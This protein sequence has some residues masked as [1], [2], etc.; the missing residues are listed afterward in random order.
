MSDFLKLSMQLAQRNASAFDAVSAEKDQMQD[1]ICSIRR[2][3]HR[4][5]TVIESSPA[6]VN[7]DELKKCLALIK[8]AEA[9]R[10][11]ATTS[12]AEEEISMSSWPLDRKA[13]HEHD[14]RP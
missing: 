10:T 14:P 5:V 11:T 2:D 6:L 8:F 1:A 9:T 4:I 7:D 13:Q 12:V 3:V